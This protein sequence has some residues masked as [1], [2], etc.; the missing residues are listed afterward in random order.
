MVLSKIQMFAYH[1]LI[2]ILEILFSKKEN[3]YQ[4]ISDFRSMNFYMMFN[5]IKRAFLLIVPFYYLNKKKEIYVTLVVYE[6]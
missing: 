6:H 3:L 2:S 4:R 1:H 5:L